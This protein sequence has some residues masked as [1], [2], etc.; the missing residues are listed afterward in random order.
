MAFCYIDK[1]CRRFNDKVMMMARSHGFHANSYLST[2]RDQFLINVMKNT[3]DQS[4][5]R[6][7]KKS[8]KIHN[9]IAIYDF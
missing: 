2:D 1:S 4:F 3:V 8:M 7:V 5:E 6:E 9:S